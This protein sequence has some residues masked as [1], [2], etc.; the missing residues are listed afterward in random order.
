M[1]TLVTERPPHSNGIA[2]IDAR[3]DRRVERLI[4]PILGLPRPFASTMSARRLPR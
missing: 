2:Q 1:G 4:H 3:A